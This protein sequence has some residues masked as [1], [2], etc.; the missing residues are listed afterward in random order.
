MSIWVNGKKKKKVL[1]IQYS[2]VS[3]WRGW[4]LARGSARGSACMFACK[5]R[6]QSVRWER[7]ILHQRLRVRS[8]PGVRTMLDVFLPRT[9]AWARDVI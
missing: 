8:V 3:V 6:G 1:G 4:D 9:T 5:G 2:T 7:L